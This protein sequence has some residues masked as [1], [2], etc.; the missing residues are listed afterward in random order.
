LFDGYK[1]SATTGPRG[2]TPAR[3]PG[4]PHPWADP[5]ASATVRGGGGR[6]EGGEVR[7][8]ILGCRGGAAPLAGDR[9]GWRGGRRQ[10]W[11]RW[12]NSQRRRSDCGG[13]DRTV[14]GHVAAPP[15]GHTLL[16][17]R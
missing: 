6:L 14:V 13:H 7:I 11:R 8:K 16:V 10:R 2:P 9:Q 5:V 3:W 1:L 15:Q 12:S 4:L 17:V